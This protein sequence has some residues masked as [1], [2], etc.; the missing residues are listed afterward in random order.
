MRGECV[1]QHRAK[2][3]KE[4]TGSFLYEEG[5]TRYIL[6]LAYPFHPFPV[7]GGIFTEGERVPFFRA[8]LNLTRIPV[9]SKAE[10]VLCAGQTEICLGSSR[11]IF[12]S[13]DLLLYFYSYY[14]QDSL[15]Q[16]KR[17]HLLMSSPPSSLDASVK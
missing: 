7:T 10:E 15:G 12:L 16:L 9:F 13:P 1:W 17:P 5:K 8:K 4:C 2:V 6:H 3:H 11:Q 14:Q